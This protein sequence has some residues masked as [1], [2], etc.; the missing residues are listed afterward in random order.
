[1]TVGIYGEVA[2]GCGASLLPFMDRMWPVLVDATK[3]E[4]EGMRRNAAF[5]MGNMLGHMGT[6]WR[7]A[8]VGEVLECMGPLLELQ[9]DDEG[10]ARDN[11][12]SA[13]AAAVTEL[14][15]A[16][17]VSEVVP[18]LVDAAP[19]QVDMEENEKLYECLVGLVATNH[20]AIEE[21]KP[22]IFVAFAHSTDPASGVKEVTAAGV[23]ACVKEFAAAH[24]EEL[25][26]IVEALGEDE[27]AAI[28]RMVSGD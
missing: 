3:A 5:A 12:V 9:E 11:A 20:P 24:G 13:M 25:S 28:S 8:H 16:E 23:A 1:M 26:A 27:G 19:L 10:L 2:I 15:D 17:W 21:L 6:E 22:Q 18:V 14:P 7:D 4:E